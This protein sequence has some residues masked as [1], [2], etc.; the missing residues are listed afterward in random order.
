MC[1]GGIGGGIVHE[2]PF[3]RWEAVATPAISANVGVVRIEWV[4]GFA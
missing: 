1:V 2:S 4:N 3:V